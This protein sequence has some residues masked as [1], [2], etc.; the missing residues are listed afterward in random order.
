MQAR[1]FVVLSLFRKK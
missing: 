1:S